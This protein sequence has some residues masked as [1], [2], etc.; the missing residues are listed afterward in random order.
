M[1]TTHF[2]FLSHRLRQVKSLALL[3]IFSIF[4]AQEQAIANVKVISDIVSV[5]YIH[6]W[7]D[8]SGDIQGAIQIKLSP[9]WKTYWRNPGPFGIK[10]IFDWTQS[11]NIK[12]IKLSWPTPKIFQQYGVK[13]IGYQNILTI[14][15]KI[16]KMVTLQNALL[17]INLEF[18]VCS[19]ICLLKTVK[20]SAQLKSQKSK[21]N[22]DLITTALT[23]LPS[24]I[25]DKV[26]SYSKCSI[27]INGDDLNVVY[28]IHL[29]K[30]PN[31]K[32]SMIT[33]Y[34]F[35]DKYIENQ[36]MKLEG[37]KLFVNASLT[38]IY[39]DEGAIERNRLTALLILEDKGF[40]IDGCD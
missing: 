39:K 23:E 13:V 14:P 28:L 32:P 38:N 15:I 24:R 22:L 12:Y 8:T 4:F 17:D 25:T 9:G 33:E 37:K 19:D 31:S 30:V 20:I 26:F 6:G 11:Q 2:Q 29:T 5:E 34:E 16:T 3:T 1:N 7:M 27:S 35:S 10:P 18:G 21:E 40:E 36:T